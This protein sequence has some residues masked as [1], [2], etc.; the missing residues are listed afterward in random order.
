LQPWEELLQTV[1][2][3]KPGTQNNSSIAP[4]CSTL[5]ERLAAA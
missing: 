1:Q 4:L 5:A 3:S 2:A